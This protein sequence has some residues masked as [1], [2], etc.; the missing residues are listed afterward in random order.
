MIDLTIFN[1]DADCQSRYSAGLSKKSAGASDAIKTAA[2]SVVVVLS[3]HE[4]ALSRQ[5]TARSGNRAFLFLIV[6]KLL[7][8]KIKYLWCSLNVQVSN[9]CNY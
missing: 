3:L 8:Y 7:C 6:I 9:L 1:S 4:E 2:F 5:I